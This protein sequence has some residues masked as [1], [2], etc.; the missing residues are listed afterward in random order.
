VI[1]GSAL[2][3]GAAALAG[4]A[5]GTSQTTAAS[6]GRSADGRRIGPVIGRNRQIPSKRATGE[7]AVRP[8]RARPGHVAASRALRSREVHT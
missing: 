5:K 7:E 3:A 4:T 8:R 1:V 6:R 2:A